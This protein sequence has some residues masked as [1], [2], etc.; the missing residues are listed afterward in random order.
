MLEGEDVYAL[1]TALLA[2]D[3]DPQG[4][5]GKFGPGTRSAVLRAQ[6]K[7]VGIGVVDGIAGGLTQ[8][9]IVRALCLDVNKKYSLPL[10]LMFGHVSL[11]SGCWVGNYSPQRDNGSYDAGV[12]Q[13]NTEHTPAR[14]GFDTN[15]SLDALGTNER[16]YFDLYKGIEQERRRWELA[17]GAWNAPA[18]AS[19]IARQEG[20][21]VAASL[22]AKPGATARDTLERYMKLATTY[23]VI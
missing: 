20:S 23:L 15:K 6:N 9:G 13:R 1:Q 7:L 11:E 17:A 12:A 2:Y 19:Y 16:K 22:T 18:Y 4:I 3:C 8:R 14:D 21:S 5:D 10:G